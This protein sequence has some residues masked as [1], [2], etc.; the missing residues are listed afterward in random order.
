[1]NFY[2]MV[3][4]HKSLKDDTPFEVLKTYFSQPVE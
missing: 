4:P 3:K 1:M 2:N